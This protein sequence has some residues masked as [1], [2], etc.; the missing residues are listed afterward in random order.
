MNRKEIA[1]NFGNN[2]KSLRTK[3][4]LTRKQLASKLGCCTNTIKTGKKQVLKPMPRHFLE[5]QHF[6]MF[7]QTICLVLKT[8]FAQKKQG[9]F[10]CFFSWNVRT[11]AQLWASHLVHPLPQDWLQQSLLG[12]ESKCCPKSD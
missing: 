2:I 9:D 11:I 1:I 7:Q 3:F 8:N 6:L 4:G 12:Q 10:P 5:W